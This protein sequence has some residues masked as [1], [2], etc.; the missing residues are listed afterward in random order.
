MEEFFQSQRV[1]LCL[2]TCL[3]RFQFNFHLFPFSSI[4]RIC[5][6][7]WEVFFKK[8]TSHI[9]RDTKPNTSFIFLRQLEAVRMYAERAPPQQKTASV[10]DW[11]WLPGLLFCT[12]CCL[13]HKP[14]KYGLV[15]SWK[16]CWLKRDYVHIC[17]FRPIRDKRTFVISQSCG[18]SERA[19]GCHT[20]SVR[21]DR[22]VLA[23]L[24]HVPFLSASSLAVVHNSKKDKFQ[25]NEI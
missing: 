17:I 11:L 16:D 4:K 22:H 5:V 14:H 8:K 1:Q 10:N 7:I 23:L 19:G 20:V 9:L 2:V 6:R 15:G 13:G 25:N 21:D 12:S 3:L 18:L 24:L